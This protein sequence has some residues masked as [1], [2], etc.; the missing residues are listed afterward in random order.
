MKTAL[1]A[2]LGL[3]ST[4]A[5]AQPVTIVSGS[6]TPLVRFLEAELDGVAEVRHESMTTPQVDAVDADGAALLVFADRAIEVWWLDP[7]RLVGRV[8]SSDVEGDAPHLLALRAVEVL[9]AALTV[10]DAIEEE[11]EPDAA[12]D[13]PLSPQGPLG[14]IGLGVFWLGSLDLEGPTTGLELEVAFRPW[15]SIE[16]AVGGWSSLLARTARFAE[17]EASTRFAGARASLHALVGDGWFRGRLGGGALLAWFRSQGE[18]VRAPN[19]GATRQA[20]TVAPYLEAA[21][22]LELASWLEA[23]VW[24][25]AG[26]FLPP[27]AVRV[28]GEDRVT[29]NGLFA[30]GLTLR[31][32][33]GS[34]P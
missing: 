4:T 32:L 16:V 31:V 1:L 28:L 8:E 23:V 6:E 10:V 20:V 26:H 13:D 34:G 17:G 30:A 33:F 27:V 24:L 22:L 11:R 12:P 19:Q 5:A 2:L 25:R 18:A 29:W 15:R 21:A 7:Q 14:S 3:G 9:N